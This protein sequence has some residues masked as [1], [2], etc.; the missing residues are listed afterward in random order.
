M[1]NSAYYFKTDIAE[2][3]SDQD[4][5]R[6]QMARDEISADHERLLYTAVSRTFCHG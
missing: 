2:L 3:A 5:I 4:K 6:M 1:D